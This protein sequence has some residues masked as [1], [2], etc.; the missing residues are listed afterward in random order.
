[1]RSS[2]GTRVSGLRKTNPDPEAT[3]LAQLYGLRTEVIDLDKNEPSSTKAP[4]WLKNN[5]PSSPGLRLIRARQAQRPLEDIGLTHIRV[6]P[7]SKK[8]I[9]TILLW[10]GESMDRLEPIHQETQGHP[11]AVWAHL[12][13]TEE[14]NSLNE[15]RLWLMSSLSEGPKS[16]QHISSQLGLS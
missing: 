14:L 7:L 16:I 15:S 9:Q 4:E 5:S 6:L 12:G 10:V 11:A 8:E 2:V 1:M 13:F 3:R